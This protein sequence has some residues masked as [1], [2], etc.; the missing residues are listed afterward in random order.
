MITEYGSV[1]TEKAT[2]GEARKA[3]TKNLM[4]L[5]ITLLVIGAIGVVLYIVGTVLDEVY[6][7]GAEWSDAFIFAVVPFTLGLIFVLAIRMQ[8]KSDLMTDDIQTGSEFFSDCII[9]R[10]FKNDEQ[11][12]VIRLN[13]SQILLVKRRAS[14]LYLMIAQGISYPVYI[15][16]LSET[17]LNTVN[18]QLKLPVSESAEIIELKQCELIN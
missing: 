3:R 6:E 4:W 15:G 11:I 10:S 5:W 14:F 16:G 18:K 2:V 1:L 9:I 17:E 7:G 8:K 12:S 13:Y